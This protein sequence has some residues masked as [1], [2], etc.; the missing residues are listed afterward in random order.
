VADAYE[1]TSFDNLGDAIDRSGDRDALALVD[2]GSGPPRFYNYSEIDALAGAAARG[3]LALGLHPGERIA[4]LSANRG[5]F[6]TA[7]LGA[8]RAGLVA[9]PVNWKLPAATLEQ[10]L[11]DCGARLVLC[12]RAR[13]PLCP[14]EL[15]R[16]VFEEGFTR[17]STPARLPRLLLIRRTRPCSSTPRARAAG[18]KASSCRITA[19]SG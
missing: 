5:E 19:T 6:L 15:P 9:V 4:I 7:F 8:M 16:L 18:P 17:C 3:L 2:L 10:I 11:R 12:D 1:P 14:T 13:L